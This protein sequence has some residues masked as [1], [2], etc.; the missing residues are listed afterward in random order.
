M[1]NQVTTRV[2]Q[3]FAAMT[4]VELLTIDD[5]MTIEAAERELRINSVVYG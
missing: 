2:I 4:G 1:S 3:D 5:Q